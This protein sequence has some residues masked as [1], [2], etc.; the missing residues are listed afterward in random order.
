MMKLLL[1]FLVTITSITVSYSQYQSTSLTSVIGCTYRNIDELRPFK[2]YKEQE[3]VLLEPTKNKYSISRISNGKN[4]IILLD[5]CTNSNTIV[6]YKILDIL[7]VGAIHKN[8][9]IIFSSC[10]IK[11]HRTDKLIALVKRVNSDKFKTIYKAWVVNSKTNKI[12]QIS[13]RNLSCIN[14]DFDAC[15]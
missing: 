1:T 11:D 8:Q 12:E 6:H 2:G 14:N 13:V 9:D 4:D 10:S 7:T 3:G 5:K 15:D